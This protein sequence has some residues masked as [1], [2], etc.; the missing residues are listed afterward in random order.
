MMKVSWIV[1]V[2][3]FASTILLAWSVPGNDG[4]PSELMNSTR[5]QSTGWCHND[6]A[7]SAF[8]ATCGGDCEAVGEKCG[9]DRDLEYPESCNT[10]YGN[11]YC[12]AE[13]QEVQVVCARE[14]DCECQAGVAQEGEETPKM[15]VRL[16]DG[17]AGAG[18]PNGDGSTPTPGTIVTDS[19]NCAM[20]RM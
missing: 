16:G 20:K 5:G 10:S 6:N 4:L 13:G 11:N 7:C 14:W 17:G 18:A 3:W 1:P 2:L 19:F 15:C 8:K 9:E 12:N